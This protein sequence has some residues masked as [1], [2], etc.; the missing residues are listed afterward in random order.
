MEFLIEY[1]L[2]LAKALTLVVAI[3]FTVASVV[4]ISVKQ[5]G[6]AEKGQIVIKNLNQR[7]DDYQAT[8]EDEVLT[9]QALKAK[10]KADKKAEKLQ[11]KQAKTQTEDKKRLFVIRFDGDVQ[12]SAVENLRE[13][14]NAILTVANANDEIVLDLES[15]GGMVHTYGLAASQLS[16]IRHADLKLTICVDKVA[17]SG[18]YL[19]ACVGHKILAAPFAIIG[20]IGVLAQL[21]NFNRALKKLD[22][23]YDIM[24][25]GEYKAPVTMFGEITDKGRDKLQSELEE[26]HQLFKQFIADN[27]A[28]VDLES[29]ATGEVWY[30]QQAIDKALIDELMTSDDYLLSQ[31]EACDIFA[32]SYVAKKSLQEK[33][34]N[35]ASLSIR[36]TINQLLS[37]DRRKSVEQS[38]S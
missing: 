3:I 38:M 13:E 20:S 31:R 28:Q 22:V 32:V 2:F 16:R 10:H 37:D 26:T 36:N 11:K 24:T 18:G 17:A 33:L 34:G 6:G 1:G 15:P 9:E 29:V 19:M 27:R 23:D 14:V 30:G 4:A 8:L 7:Y 21:P 25:A 35:L 5:K 12:A